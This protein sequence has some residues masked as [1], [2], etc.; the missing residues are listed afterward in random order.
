MGVVSVGVHGQLQPRDVV[1][2]LAR[3]VDRLAAKPD[4]ASPA[5]LPMVRRSGSAPSRPTVSPAA[6]M[7][8]SS[9][10]AAARRAPRPT[11]ARGPQLH[12]A[13]ARG[14]RGGRR[15]A[16][17]SAPRHGAGAGAAAARGCAGSRAAPPPA[18]RRRRG[19]G[20]SRRPT[21]GAPT[22]L[23]DRLDARGRRRR[24]RRAQG[25]HL[26]AGSRRR[27]ARQPS[28]AARPRRIGRL[29]LPPSRRLV[30]RRRPLAERRVQPG[31]PARASVVP[32]GG[33]S[34]CQHRLGV[35]LQRRGTRSAPAR[36]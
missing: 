5:A 13:V 1:A 26:A 25:I 29:Q 31:R 4:L 35:D 21:R 8:D 33:G 10:L 2:R 32:V 15:A 14:G 3:Q 18:R 34:S 9:S 36:A 28:A 19:V 23:R 16:T 30:A 17:P 22:R 12:H 24:R 27:P 20:G 7:R 6:T 11:T